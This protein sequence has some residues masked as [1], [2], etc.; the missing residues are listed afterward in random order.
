MLGTAWGRNARASN[1]T[2]HLMPERRITHEIA[3]HTASVKV[4]TATI[5]NSVFF[6]P[7]NKRSHGRP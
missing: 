1:A 2:R 5:K 6:A 4:G 7:A 3:T